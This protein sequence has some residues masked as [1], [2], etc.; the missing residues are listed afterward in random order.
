[1]CDFDFDFGQRQGTGRYNILDELHGATL[2]S[3]I[4]LKTGYHQIIVKEGDE[5]KT[6]FKIKFC[7]YEWLVMGFGL[8]NGPST[9]MRLM[10]HVLRDCIGHFLVVYFDDLLIYSKNLDEH[11]DHL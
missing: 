9:F 11:L 10:N 7:L 4:D 3:N 8:T 5:W 2:F 6:S 1:M